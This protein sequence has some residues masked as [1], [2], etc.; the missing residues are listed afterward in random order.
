MR[1]IILLALFCLMTCVMSLRTFQ[2]ILHTQLSNNNLKEN[3]SNNG[4][5]VKQM[6]NKIK[7]EKLFIKQ[8]EAKIVNKLI[9]NLKNLHL[10]SFSYR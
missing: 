7:N 2:S 10:L 3:D 1:I 6:S 5:G 4:G 9:K 8:Y